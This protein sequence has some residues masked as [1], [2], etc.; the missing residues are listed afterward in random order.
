[1]IRALRV[2][3][4]ACVFL[5][6]LSFQSGVK[7]NDSC[8]PYMD[9]LEIAKAHPYVQATRELNKE[10][11]AKVV[12]FVGLANDMSI[13]IDTGYLALMMDNTVKFV[14]GADGKVCQMVT[15]PASA[16]PA[17]IEILVGRPA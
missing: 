11:V 5:L 2:Y 1:M 4:T 17:L 13:K 8:I 6:C 16:V 7:A 14:L 3:V 12:E 9:H 10:E 15:I